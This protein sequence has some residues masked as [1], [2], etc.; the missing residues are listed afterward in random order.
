MRGPNSA[1]R[2]AVRPTIRSQKWVRCDMGTA[3]PTGQSTART[4]AGNEPMT[5][6]H[7]LRPHD[8]CVASATHVA[9]ATHGRARTRAGCALYFACDVATDLR[10]AISSG[11][12][13][14]LAVVGTGAATGARA[15]ARLCQPCCTGCA[16][17]TAGSVLMAGTVGG[18][19][20]ATATGAAVVTG[21]GAAAGTAGTT[22]G[23]AG[24]SCVGAPAAATLAATGCPRRAKY[25]PSC[26]PPAIAT[27]SPSTA[28]A[29]TSPPRDRLFATG[30]AACARADGGGTVATEGGT[31]SFEMLDGVGGRCSV[32][33]PAGVGGGGK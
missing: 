30:A 23:G 32:G 5:R 11:S 4:R 9:T 27:A 25:F 24:K 3:L 21:A 22:G 28:D 1:A 16:T 15:A 2:M 14:V 10:I 18:V 8:T 20:A 12:I 26:T 19:V 7:A 31:V 6:R 17:R 29:A 13:P 33:R